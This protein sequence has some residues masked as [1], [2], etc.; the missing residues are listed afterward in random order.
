LFSGERVSGAG[1]GLPVPYAAAMPL[2]S[3]R[4]DRLL[5]V[6]RGRV[7]GYRDVDAD[8]P[9]RWTGWCRQLLAHGGDLVVPPGQPDPDL[10]ELLTHS[11]A[12]PPAGRLVP[13]EH[14][15]CHINAA[16]LWIDGTV[17]SIGT[18]YALSEDGLWRQHS[19]G[20]D[21]DDSLVE[22]TE[23]RQRY[24]GLTLSG[25]PALQFAVSNADWHLTPVFTAGGPRAKQLAAILRSGA[26]PTDAA[27]GIHGR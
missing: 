1:L 19:W 26:S 22:T 13:G 10:D 18:G 6:Y 20:V 23:H 16:I 3:D 21:A 25:F 17:A 5:D 11:T 24:V 15:A 4:Y 27:A 7:A 9:R 8:F 14:N 12:H 2:T